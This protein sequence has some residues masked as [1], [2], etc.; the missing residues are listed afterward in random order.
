MA[1][2]K[3][4]PSSSPRMAVKLL[5][6]L[7]A[8]DEQRRRV[9]LKVFTDKQ[10]D[11]WAERSKAAALFAQAE[12]FVGQVHSAMK[13]PVVGY[14]AHRFAWLCQ[15]VVELHAALEADGASRMKEAR[16]LRDQLFRQLDDARRQL[17]SALSDAALG[18]AGLTAQ[19]HDRNDQPRGVPRVLEES[20]RGLLV[21]AA[22]L[23]DTDD[24]VLLAEDSGL[25]TEFLASVTTTLATFSEANQRTFSVDKGLD[26]GPTNRIE[27]RVLR[28]MAFALRVL[29]RAKENGAAINLPAPGAILARLLRS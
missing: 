17:A 8:I 29:R 12:R 23:R 5:A 26:S 14:S 6:K 18:N 13:Q 27:G 11:D 24:G 9:Y 21:L 2:K 22:E 7:P 1:A 25:T 15:L 16:L 4:A 10:C 28:E 19:V 3:K 20:V